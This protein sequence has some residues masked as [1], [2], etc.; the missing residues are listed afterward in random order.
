MLSWTVRQLSSA[1]FARKQMLE[2]ARE[3]LERAL[4]L[5]SSNIEGDSFG[6]L[7]FACSRRMTERRLSS[8]KS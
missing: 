5:D 1:R 3:Y 7:R 4:R 8:S 2:R 6:W